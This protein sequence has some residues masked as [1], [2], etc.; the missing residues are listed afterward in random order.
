MRPGIASF[1]PPVDRL[2]VA[3]I[4][5]VAANIRDLAFLDE[6]VPARLADVR[7]L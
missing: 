3:L 2:A 7:I 1:P 6:D 4:F 5:E